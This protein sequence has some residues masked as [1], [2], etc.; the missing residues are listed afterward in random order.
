MKG[1]MECFFPL[2]E[3][4]IT[5]SEPSFCALSS[6]AMVLNALNFDIKRVWKGSWRWVSE[7]MLQ[8]ES[9]HVC[10][11]SLEK[12][13][14]N[15][16]NFNEFLKLAHCHG[17]VLESYRANNANIDNNEAFNLF[18]QSI[19][20]VSF[21]S[22]ANTFIIVNFSRTY[23]GQTGIGHFSPIGGYHKEKQLVLVLDV[24]RFKYPPYWVFII[25]YYNYFLCL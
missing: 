8:C 5:Q 3:Q 25:I 2:S 16:M 23:L 6:L 12:I 1:E 11:H 17:V 24:A 15:G 4:F 20:K 7:E 22:S 9:L 19:E 14:A 13:K 10:G 21:S 18:K